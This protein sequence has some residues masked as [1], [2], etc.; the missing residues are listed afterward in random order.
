MKTELTL[1]QLAAIGAG[2]SQ[3]VE[4]QALIG[5]L[6]VHPT[7]SGYMGDQ[8]FREAFARAV[9]DAVLGNQ[10]TA[11]DPYAELKKAHAEGK[12]IQ[13]KPHGCSWEDIEDPDFTAHLR[14][15]RIKPDEP[16]TFEAHGKT[17][18]KHKAGDPMPCDGEAMVEVL[19]GGEILGRRAIAKVLRWESYTPSADIIGWRYAD[20]QPKLET[21]SW[22]PAVGDVVQIKSG[23]PKMTVALLKE[24]LCKCQWF[25]GDEADLETFEIATLQPVTK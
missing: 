21:P 7:R 9:R 10:V 20:E 17:W 14:C 1:T 25:R 3:F 16:S 18:T 23:G 8:P 19:L 11:T 2:A 5:N 4:G 12:V 6:T 24:T 22:T 15:Y 13:F